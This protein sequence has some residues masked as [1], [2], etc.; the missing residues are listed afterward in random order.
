[1]NKQTIFLEPT[2][3]HDYVVGKEIHCETKQQLHTGDHV[4]VFKDTIAVSTSV[5]VPHSS[6][7]SDSIGVEGLVT[8]VSQ[9][10]VAAIALAIRKI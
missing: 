3:Y 8:G 2:I 4:M 7:Q 5:P 9:R 10:G 6:Q 1:M